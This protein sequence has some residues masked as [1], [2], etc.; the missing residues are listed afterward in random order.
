MGGWTDKVGRRP[1]I[2][3]P[4]IGSTLEVIVCLATIYFKLPLYVLFVGGFLHGIFGYFTTIVLS[5]MAYIADTTEE[6][7]RAFRLGKYQPYENLHEV[8]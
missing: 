5:C 4:C 2:I 8:K 6:S 1:G 3:S 7:Q